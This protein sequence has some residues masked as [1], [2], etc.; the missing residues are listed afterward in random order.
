MKILVNKIKCKH[1]GDV[2]E[3]KFR[4][5]FQ[6]CKCGKVAVDGGH[7]YLRRVFSTSPTEDFEDLS[8][9]VVDE[10]NDMRYNR[11]INEEDSK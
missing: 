11:I 9:C 2:I 3:S 6:F 1:C 7:E 10:E 5:D 4:H 8:E